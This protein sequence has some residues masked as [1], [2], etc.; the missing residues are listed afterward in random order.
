[1]PTPSSG[2]SAPPDASSPVSPEDAAF[3]FLHG[4]KTPCH[5]LV[6]YSGGS[7]ST[8]LL[9]ALAA[10]L[11]ANPSLAVTLSAA[12][13]DHGLRAGSAEEAENAAKLCEMLG[14]AHRVLRWEGA[15]PAAGIQ[16]AGRQA[17]Y[18]L[19]ACHARTVGADLIVTG[20]T[21]DD[22][23]ETSLMRQARNPD[24]AGGISS[25]VLV[26]RQTWVC[27]PFLAVRRDAIRNYLAAREVGWVDDPSND[28]VMFERVR[29]RKARLETA[30]VP[31]FA[32]L[33]FARR[34][35][36]DEAA[37]FLST[38]VTIHASRV[39][40][41]S[42][43]EFE[44]ANPAHLMAL[45][46]LAAFIGGRE[47]V[48]GRQSSGRIIELLSGEGNVRSAAERVVF[49]RRKNRLYLVRERRLLPEIT[50]AG[51]DSA[52][53]DNR[54]RIGNPGYTPVTIAARGAS[55]DGEPL[56]AGRMPSLPKAVSQ[57]ARQTEPMVIG[58]QATTLFV[59]PV[60][61]NFDQFLPVELF[62]IANVL[63]L[64]GGLAHFPKVPVR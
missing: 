40:E 56:L 4:L 17:R 2:H 15:K 12:T 36:A 47:H 54:F 25:A 19:L 51:G 45:M 39:A 42:L 30:P 58:G 53:W 50:I 20:H 59:E 18:G 60:I 5:L 26:N 44:L 9:V 37:V 7:D 33:A 35:L 55:E 27:R 34:A 29:V 64:L 14:I 22:Q 13:V 8:G 46:H 63:A 32:A 48:A 10:C 24:S 43:E 21:L 38:H 57:L 6:G 1:M 62:E 11:A 3:E 49:D 16:A 31:D 23:I 41:L 61:A 52:V 28:N